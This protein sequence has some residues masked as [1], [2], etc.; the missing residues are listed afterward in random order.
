MFN[1]YE[2]FLIPELKCPNLFI[3]F[4]DLPGSIENSNQE[5]I[6]FVSN[7]YELLFKDYIDNESCIQIVSFV[8][9]YSSKLNLIHPQYATILFTSYLTLRSILFPEVSILTISFQFLILIQLKISMSYI[10]F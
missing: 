5:S 8:K 4:P 10:K 3:N 6:T 2:N 9:S 1:F 7:F